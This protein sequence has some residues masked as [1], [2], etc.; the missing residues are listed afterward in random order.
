MHSRRKCSDVG[1]VFIPGTL[2]QT[3]SNSPNPSS[4]PVC[5]CVCVCVCMRV[6]AHVCMCMSA[7]VRVCV[8]GGGGDRTPLESPRCT[9][10]LTTPAARDNIRF[11][12]STPAFT[13]PFL[14]APPPPTFNSPRPSPTPPPPSFPQ[15]RRSTAHLSLSTSFTVGEKFSTVSGLEFWLYKVTVERL[16]NKFCQ[17]HYSARAPRRHPPVC[18]PPPT[19]PLPLTRII[20]RAAGRCSCTLLA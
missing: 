12:S 15:P 13:P 14:S 3:A 5:V 9:A 11:D 10:S 4:V 16:F 18:P 17:R 8:C 2:R 20:C 7:C 19:S 1:G 6:R